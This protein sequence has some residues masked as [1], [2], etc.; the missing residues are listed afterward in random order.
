[1]RPFEIHK[2]NYSLIE[3]QE[4]LLRAA[5]LQGGEAEDAW[6]AW[7]QVV[8]LENLDVNS[9]RLLPLLYKNLREQQA[10][11]PLPDKLQDLYRYNWLR[12]QGFLRDLIA[13]LKTLRANG[14]Q[15][16][17]LKGMALAIGCYGDLGARP[18]HDLDLLVKPDDA[19]R[20]GELLMASGWTPTG[21]PEIMLNEKCIAVF[22]EYQF[23]NKS[24]T[25]I[26]LHWQTRQKESPEEDGFY[27]QGA[28]ELEAMGA[29]IPMMNPED[30]LVYALVHCLGHRG[31]NMPRAIADMHTILVKIGSE[32]KWDRV[33]TNIRNSRLVLPA[34][35]LFRYMTRILGSPIPRPVQSHLDSLRVP[36][37]ERYVYYAVNGPPPGASKFSLGL[38]DFANVYF[39][40]VET[41]PTHLAMPV[42]LPELL[43]QRWGLR[44]RRQVP[45]AMLAKTLKYLRKRIKL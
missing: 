16:M 30:M 13:V 21:N 31:E 6:R 15:T 33:I 10:S 17:V 11:D 34:R 32:I 4:L 27:W 7:K 28:V 38:L 44:H 40:I 39:H 41:A 29:L 19:L 5:L 24:N 37:R 22:N 23:N 25:R 8:V 36:G 18:M 12:N 1:M 3:Q 42:M 45:V 2:I 26:D 14:I 20:A 35:N 43:R 9:S